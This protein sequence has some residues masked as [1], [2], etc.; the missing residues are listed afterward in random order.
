MWALTQAADWEFQW[1]ASKECLWAARQVAETAATKGDARAVQLG[2][3]RADW[4]AGRWG[5]NL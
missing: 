3:Q 5:M 4:R 2:L 1:V